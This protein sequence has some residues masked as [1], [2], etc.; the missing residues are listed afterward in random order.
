MFCLA[1]VSASAAWFSNWMILVLDSLTFDLGFGSVSV[2]LSSSEDENDMAI[3][4][5]EAL[6]ASTKPFCLFW[7]VVSASR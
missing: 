7:Y 1:V 2:L 3:L 5:S 6:S 4:D